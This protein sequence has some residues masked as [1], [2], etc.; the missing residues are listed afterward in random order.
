MDPSQPANQLT[1]AMDGMDEVIKEFLVES[2]EGLDRFDH[3]LIALEKDKTSR[4][5]LDSIFR[6][7]HT[8]KGTGGVLGYDKLVSISHLGESVLSRMRDGVLL[9]SPPIATALLAMADSLRHILE[10][11]ASSG[12]EGDSDCSPVLQRLSDVL[13]EA[14][15][16]A[17]KATAEGVSAP[18][19]EAPDSDGAPRLGEILITS[20][21]CKAG[22]V[23]RQ[24]NC[25]RPA[26]RD[27]WARSWS[28]IARWRRPELPTPSR[29]KSNTMTSPVTPFGWTWG[30]WTR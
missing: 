16:T 17:G 14:P 6:A 7:V 28:T 23:R 4:E 27:R 30:C 21:Q 25:R 12:Q 26:T 1:N 24:C 3:D 18:P 11:I 22:D 29:R 10:Q 20:E 5:L 8:I 2:N 9:L 19:A 15:P 13:K